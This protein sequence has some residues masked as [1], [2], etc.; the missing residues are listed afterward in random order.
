MRGIRWEEV[1]GVELVTPSHP[2]IQQFQ[3]L[4][5]RHIADTL[6]VTAHA[7]QQER[8]QLVALFGAPITALLTEEALLA[9][10]IAHHYTPPAPCRDCR[11]WAPDRYHPGQDVCWYGWTGGP[12]RR[13]RTLAPC[14]AF[15]DRRFQAEPPSRWAI[16]HEMKEW[17]AAHGIRYHGGRWKAHRDDLAREAGTLGFAVGIQW[18]RTV[19]D[20]LAQCYGDQFFVPH[21]WLLIHTHVGTLQYREVDG[22][23]RV[24]ATHAFIYEIK[25]GP[26]AY[27]K[28]AAEY[29]PLLQRVYPE[30]TFTPI[31]INVHNPYHGQTPSAAPIQQLA[32][33]DD[34]QM[35]GRYQLLVLPPI[36]MVDWEE[37]DLVFTID[38]ALPYLWSLRCRF[39]S[40][41]LW[42][43]DTENL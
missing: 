24:D 8:D 39:C 16:L 25:H 7:R 38:A 33:L 40:K 32:I 35:N 20:W 17:M 21:R 2:A 15:T 4:K 26:P 34:R 1:A 41:P 6:E 37:E 3:R 12:P 42:L 9:Q 22:I 31:E 36:L 5:A 19:R 28:L 18:E 29:V 10:Y 27:P 43:N 11:H 30:R 23:E 13:L 14:D